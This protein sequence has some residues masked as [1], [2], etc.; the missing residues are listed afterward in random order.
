[1]VEGGKRKKELR[2]LINVSAG[3]EKNPGSI[4]EGR[5]ESN[6]KQVIDHV[7]ENCGNFTS[8]SGIL[9]SDHP[10]KPLTAC[11]WFIKAD[12]G[13][14]LKIIIQKMDIEE[15]D[16]SDSPDCN[17]RDDELPSCSGTNVNLLDENNY[18]LTRYST[19]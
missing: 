1:M 16:P 18:Q 17:E 6:G 7:F 14:K 13:V 19:F 15:E 11:R 8:N 10:Y 3:E 5:I 12:P 4:L 2:D 9:E